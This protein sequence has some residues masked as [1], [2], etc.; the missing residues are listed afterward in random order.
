MFHKTINSIN[1]CGKKLGNY[2][3]AR[4]IYEYVKRND[5]KSASEL[6][7][8]Y[9]FLKF[10]PKSLTRS[11]TIYSD[12]L[13]KEQF[14]ILKSNHDPNAHSNKHGIILKN[15]GNFN[16]NITHKLGLNTSPI[17]LDKTGKH[18]CNGLCLACIIP[19]NVQKGEH[20]IGIVD[21]P[22]DNNFKMTLYKHFMIVN[23][24]D[25]RSINNPTSKQDLLFLNI[26][27]KKYLLAHRE[28]CSREL[29]I[30]LADTNKSM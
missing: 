6:S 12:N 10:L 21:L 20:L 24:F 13:S 2:K 18:Y 9:S 29:L 27:P 14:E 28:N 25:I 3:I 22:I 30:D 5:I 23:K 1:L 19:R 11:E 26:S 4:I 16:L 17:P 7:Q 15:C 8:R